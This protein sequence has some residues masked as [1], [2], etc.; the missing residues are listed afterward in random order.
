MKYIGLLTF[1]S[2]IIFSCSKS[3]KNTKADFLN[4]GI[5]AEK[6]MV[7]CAN[8]A[9]AK[10]GKDIMAK[11]GTAYDAAI[12]VEF[13]LAVCH[14]SAGNIGG[15]GFIV[16]REK[17][18]KT[19]SLDYR[20]RAPAM[21]RENMYRDESDNIIKGLSTKTHL[22]SGVPGT[23]DG[24]I[25]LY[26]KYGTLPFKVLI[27]PAIDLAYSGFL[28][29]AIQVNQLNKLK[30][31]FI[32]RNNFVPAYVN[33]SIWKYG[34]TLKLPNLA[35]TLER[36]RD[37]GRD[38][39]YSGKTA[40]L[41]VKE[42]QRG[43]GVISPSDLSNYT[44]IWRNTVSANYK[45]YEV[46]SMGPPSSGGI[47]LLQLMQM[48]E[49]YPFQNIKHN[50]KKYIHYLAEAERRVYADR[51]YFLGDPDFYSV[52]TIKLTE[53]EY[54]LSRFKDFNPLMASKSV[55]IN[56]GSIFGYESD[57]TTHYSIIDEYG[58]AVSATTTLNFSYG[59]RIIV[60]GTGF[61]LNNEMDDFSSKPGVAN[62]YGLVGGDANTIQPQKR[63][64]SSMT[65]TILTKNDK[66]Y[67]V[68]GSPGGSKIIT[69][70]FQSILNVVE[71]NMTMQEAVA[72]PRFH[73]QWFPDYISYENGSLDSLTIDSLESMGH[74]MKQVKPFCRVDGILV[75]KNGS[76]E[77]GA[78]P[79]G[80]DVAMGN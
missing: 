68:I 22:S 69:S 4:R 27:Q 5:I 39:F 49:S 71:F 65:P 16:I 80:D 43:N 70:V 52:P 60:E 79:R 31:K 3:D 14:P 53:K 9:A 42:M 34:D 36:I 64:L 54:V 47:C 29:T 17:N 7:V 50:N 21:A 30:K 37:N 62:A 59:S 13:A 26:N 48:L 24:M 58:N 51:A 44:A 10:I 67:M 6:S 41:I 75:L 35:Q 33:D 78:D 72:S 73:H 12:A 15:G 8:P 32:K 18:G 38:G 63:M 11:G 66:L 57:E 1:I 40:N 25:K 56:H 45:D 28:L 74:E 76:L 23:V 46:I 19:I 55:D 20:E 77:G 2:I 61:I